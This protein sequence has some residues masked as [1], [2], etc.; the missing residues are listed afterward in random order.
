M[1]EKTTKNKHNSDLMITRRHRGSKRPARSCMQDRPLGRKKIAAAAEEEAAEVFS[2]L[3]LRRSARVV[4]RR[5]QSRA[6]LSFLD[7]H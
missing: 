1:L 7:D 3:D 4:E 2:L 5:K 6:L